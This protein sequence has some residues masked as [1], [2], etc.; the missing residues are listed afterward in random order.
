MSFYYNSPWGLY[1]S[2]RTPEENPQ[3]SPDERENLLEEHSAEDYFHLSIPVMDTFRSTQ[4]PSRTPR[5]Q[6]LYPWTAPPTV[7]P[8]V[9]SVRPIKP[10]SIDLRNLEYVDLADAN[11]MCAIC[12]CPFVTPVKLECDHVF[13]HECLA[14]AL[15]HQLGESRNCPTCRRSTREQEITTVP[16][17]ISR[18]LDELK[19]KCPMHDQGC[20][21]TIKRGMLQDHVERYCDFVEVECPAQACLFRL[22]RKDKTKDWCQHYLVACTDCDKECMEFE[23]EDHRAKHCKSRMASCPGCTAEVLYHGLDS[24]LH[25]CHAANL[26]CTAAAYGCDFVSN[27]IALDQ[28]QSTCPLHKLVPFL[29]TQKIQLE[30]HEAAIQQLQH[31]N[32]ILET[33]FMHIQ[34]ALAKSINLVEASTSSDTDENSLA[35]F[36]STAAHLLSLHEALREEVG[37]VRSAVSDLDAKSSMMIYNESLRINEEMAHSNAALGNTR[38]QV[39]WLIS[40]RLQTQQ[41][42]AM[43]RT[44]SSN[45]ADVLRLGSNEM[46]SSSGGNSTTGAPGQ[47]VRSLSDSTRQETKL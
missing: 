3:R 18:I 38:M 28:H 47:T 35:P 20:L 29:N 24:H 45:G 31:K 10:G 6:T 12:H 40:S 13:C 8:I 33:S 11:L 1:P 15:T 2:T 17:L 22:R 26:P 37:R 46:G 25:A 9:P 7:L 5:R 42:A 41:R 36:D 14:K 34:D 43:D 30:S 4:F 39:Q 32:S 27:R 23:L 19:V 44:Q 16:R 21:E